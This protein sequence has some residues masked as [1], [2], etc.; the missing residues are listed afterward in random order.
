MNVD[1]WLRK[2]F[3]PAY[4]VGWMCAGMLV[5]I[6]LAQVVH[7]PVGITVVMIVS[8]AAVI[9]FWNRR[10]YMI[11]MISAVGLVVGI[12]RGSEG[13]DSLRYIQTMAD[14]NIVTEGIV[15][16]DPELSARG[17]TRVSISSVAINGVLTNGQIWLTLRGEQSHIKRG[18]MIRVSGKTKNGFGPYQLTMSYPTIVG[19]RSSHDPMI[20]FRDNFVSALRKSVIEPAASLG[21]G[22][23]VGQKTAL[24]SSLEE[25]LRIVGLTHLVVASGYNLTI[26]VR[27]A[28][29]L[30][31]KHSKFL[32]AFSSSSMIIGFMAVSGASPSM[33]RAGIVAGLSMLAWYYGRAFHPFLLLV[34][35]AA[36]T[37]MMNPMYL[38]SDIGWWL[39]FLAF[40][41]VMIVA[42]LMTRLFVGEKKLPTIVQIIIETTAAQLMTLPLIL[43]IFGNLP[44]LSIIAN[45]VTAPLIP[46]AMLLTSIAGLVTM[47]VPSFGAVI[48]LPAEIL[49][50]Y[51]VAVV[52][53]LSAPPWAQQSI[54][55]SVEAMVVVY[56]IL[57]IIGV[58]VWRRTGINFRSQTIIE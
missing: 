24:P 36:L 23:V 35:V 12:I 46:M 20:A 2:R 32:V 38:W 53:W 44:I 47:L 48:G 56:S 7:V 33:T 25:Q 21:V 37:A 11:M 43:L 54:A 16:E 17:D 30:F 10:W 18:D 51:F 15:A 58:I 26:L 34:Y 14:K 39:S 19:Y 49:L 8:L 5:G 27:A 31:E 9:A 3:H 29:R 22:F 50:S 55:I 41:G 28:K 45:L 13:L 52:R 57:V 42:P 4:I 1:R 40:A 6:G